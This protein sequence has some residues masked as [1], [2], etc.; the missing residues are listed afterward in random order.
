VEF[1]EQ[2]LPVPGLAV[3]KRVSPT[4][5]RFTLKDSIQPFHDGSPFTSG[6]VKATL[7]SI[8]KPENASPHRGDLISI[9]KIETP[10]S[11]NID[12][13]LKSPDS[14][15]PDRLRVGILPR[16]KIEEKHPFHTQPVG[17]GP[18]IFLLWPEEGSLK[19]KRMFDGQ[20]FEFLYV[21]DHTVRVLK[22][23][24]GE[25]DMLQNDLPPE[26]VSLLAKDQR[27]R[28]I[29]GKGSNFTYLG[30]NMEDPVVGRLGVRK[31]IAH[32]LNREDMIRYVLGGAAR[33][34][35]ALLPPEH[36][37]GN[38][39]LIFYSYNPVKAKNF[40]NQ[41][42]FDEQRLPKITYKT[43]SDPFRV[44]LATI[45]Q[46]QLEKVGF[47]VDVRSYDW[48]TFYGDI[49]GGRFQMFSLTWVGIT[50][51]DIFHM[52]FHSESVPPNGANRGRFQNA[53]A[54]QLIV[55][56]QR[57]DTRETQMD[58]YRHLQ[59]VLLDQLPYIPLWYEDHFFAGNKNLEGYQLAPDGN[60]D[61][62]SRISLNRKNK[63]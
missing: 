13:F 18:F 10:D 7:E 6:D 50:T 5:F 47:E 22:L 17:N 31:A 42:G 37:A 36:W 51:P 63:Q 57:A 28:V 14:F 2:N 56:A 26:L 48:G 23:L 43:S 32:A 45:I 60:Y 8:L 55:Q 12:I 54:D 49:K 19:I 52:I 46:R 9:Q 62:L 27:V 21:K 38:Q 33:P 41:E 61:G 35:S 34:A 30:F 24:K 1:D 16:K 20:I 39:N 11:R 53:V 40:L 4:Q 15:F 29:K 3:W 59:E 58:L 44:R 25:I